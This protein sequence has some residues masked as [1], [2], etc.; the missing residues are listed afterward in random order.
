MQLISIRQTAFS[1]AIMV[2]LGACAV[3]PADTTEDTQE[4]AVLVLS[5]S[6]RAALDSGA[7]L[8]GVAGAPVRSSTP[9]SAPAGA[10]TNVVFNSCDACLDPSQVCDCRSGSCFTWRRQGTD[11]LLCYAG[12]IFLYQFTCPHWVRVRC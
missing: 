12:T 7:A 8:L 3:S 11:K 9:A 10:E 5:A 6:E 4:T 2:C 1:L